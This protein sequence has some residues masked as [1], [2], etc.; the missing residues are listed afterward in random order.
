ML[1]ENG[2]AARAAGEYGKHRKTIKEGGR[3]R[4]KAVVC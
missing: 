4:N 3:E 1:Q 2:S